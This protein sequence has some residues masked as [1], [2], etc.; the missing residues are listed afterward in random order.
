MDK[1]TR[2]GIS[3]EPELLERFDAI[4]KKKGYKNRSEA[5]R[6]L[7]RES[8]IKDEWK[9]G[10]SDVVGTITIVYGHEGSTVNKLMDIQHSHH[11]RISST[12]HVHVDEQTCIEVLVAGGA[13]EDVIHLADHIRA[14][15]GVQHCE[16]VMTS[17]SLA[18][19]HTHPHG[20]VHK[21]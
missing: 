9:G 18:G 10:S 6:D 8:I 12:T 5:L 14:I 17:K 1:V 3:L 11:A 19:K 16:L 20:H 15:K 7:V 13:P 21:H 2:T 4:I